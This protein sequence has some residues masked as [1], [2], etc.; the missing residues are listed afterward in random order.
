MAIIPNQLTIMSWNVRSLTGARPY[1]Y[2]LM[3]TSDVIVISEHRLYDCQLHNLESIN[4]N[5][6]VTSKASKSIDDRTC[7]V[8]SGIGGIAMFWRNSIGHR[9]VTMKVN[10]DR[11]CAIHVHGDTQNDSLFI[12]GV[13]LPQIA[14]RISSYEG[15][16]EVLDKLIWSCRQQGEVVVIGDW[17]CQ[18]TN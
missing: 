10:S 8:R 1:I 16:V 5:F 11:I 4:H 13:Y 14:C 9:I 3:E 6:A 7:D 2:K 15:E 18:V 17:N 12:I